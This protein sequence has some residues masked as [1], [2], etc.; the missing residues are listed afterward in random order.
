[1][2]AVEKLSELLPEAAR[3]AGAA[4]GLLSARVAF[5][6]RDFLLWFRPAAVQVIEW[7]GNPDKPVEETEAGSA[8]IL[9]DRIG[10]GRA[11]YEDTSTVRTVIDFHPEDCTEL[12]TRRQS[13]SRELQV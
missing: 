10:T 4:S 5:G 1:M 7:A 8:V 9:N 2:I 11:R 12:I 3:Y 13:C 6:G